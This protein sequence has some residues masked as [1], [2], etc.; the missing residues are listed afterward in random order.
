M[1]E[2]RSHDCMEHLEQNHI[3]SLPWPALSLDLSHIEHLWDKL[4]KSIRR[5][6]N[7]TETQQ[8]LCLPVTQK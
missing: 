8:I 6:Q 7:P 1:L 2:L 3:R 4:G 5:R